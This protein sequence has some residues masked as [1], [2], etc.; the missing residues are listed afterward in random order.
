[1]LRTWSIPTRTAGRPLLTHW[2]SVYVPSWSVDLGLRLASRVV[3]VSAYSRDL[4]PPWAQVKS[5]VVYNPFRPSIDRE[6]R[7]EIRQRIREQNGIPRNAAVIGFFG[8]LLQRKRPHV[9]LKIL[10]QLTHTADGRPIYGVLC[11]E[12]LEP[13]DNVYFSMLRGEN[14][15]GRVVSPGFVGNVAEWMAACDVMVAP[16]VDEPL[17]R[18][19][20]EAQSVG[21]PII[22]SSDGGLREVVEQGISGLIVDP[23]DFESWVKQVR[24][25]LDEADYADCLA[26]GG[27]TAAARLTVERHA[28]AIEQIYERLAGNRAA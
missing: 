16:A 14:W 10:R 22:V 23:D 28:D 2:R 12:V 19:G 3:C 7:A 24:R 25:V 11:G 26:R 18:V 6:R 4:L 1:M 27:I 20:V 17:A 9:L 8:A 13:R 5:E 15:Q 21:L